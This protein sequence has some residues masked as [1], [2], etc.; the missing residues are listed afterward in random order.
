MADSVSILI[1]VHNAGDWLEPALESAVNQTWPNREIIAIDDGSTDGSAERLRAW[2]NRIRVKCRGNRGGNPTRN[3]LL[4]LATGTWVQFLD[5]DDYLLP[6]KI[7]TQM[8]VA[9]AHPGAVMLYS[10]LVI[11]YHGPDG[12]SRE[13]WNPHRSDGQ[14]DPWTYHLGWK[15]TQ[16]GGAL[17][18]REVLQQAGGWDE[19]Q[20]CC[21]DNGVFF[22]MLKTGRPIL[23]SPLAEAVY[24]RFEKGS[25]STSNKPRLV[26][27][28]FR[29]LDEGESW[30]REHNQLTPERLQA[31]NQMRFNM[32]RKDWRNNRRRSLEIMAR[33][34]QSDPRFFPDPGPEAPA[35]YRLCYRLLG[36]SG[37]E[38]IAGLKR[39]WAS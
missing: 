24:R 4:E 39:R 16:T 31:A 22:R 5:A 29:L 18:R 30:L 12:P 26:R 23:R 34:R 20:P 38:Q 10:P 14:H 28:I 27:E 8:A 13:I 35:A 11:E 19:A 36:F 37:A 6:E 21:Q 1:P 15:L 9:E 2:Q 7:Q 3:E 17:F 33:I 25:V 32:A